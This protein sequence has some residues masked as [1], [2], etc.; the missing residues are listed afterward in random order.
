[1]SIAKTLNNNNKKI[2]NGYAFPEL[3]PE[4]KKN[5]LF[6]VVRFSKKKKGYKNGN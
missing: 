5:Q 2:P 1:M 3:I 6:L 4:L